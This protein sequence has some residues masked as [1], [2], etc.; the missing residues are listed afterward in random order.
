MKVSIILPTHNGS[1]FIARAIEGVLNQSFQDYEFLIID[2]GSLDNTPEIIRN[3]S[4]NDNRIRYIRQETN[5]GIIA[6]LNHGLFLSKG[7]YIARIDDD[8][9]WIDMKKLDKQVKY[10]DN[11]PDYVLVGTGYNIADE[12]GNGIHRPNVMES[13]ESIRKRIL[14]AADILH[15]TVMFRRSAAL[16]LGGYRH[17]KRTLL[18][19]DLDFWLR[20]ATIGKFAT[21]PMRAVLVTIRNDSISSRKAIRQL[22]HAIY[23][24]YT[25]RKLFDHYYFSIF[26]RSLELIIYGLMG[27]S[28]YSPIK[29]RIINFIR[30]G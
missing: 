23:I 22:F 10:L 24:T 30:K 4:Y 2:D 5:N 15:P 19:E 16:K 7:E 28:P 3:Y 13:D 18:V 17:D 11:H 27:I 14:W 21:L 6:T 29:L 25:Y 12:N 1:R 26:R 20:L 9:I 8:D